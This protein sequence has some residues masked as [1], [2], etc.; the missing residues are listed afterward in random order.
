M[1]IDPAAVQ[2]RWDEIRGREDCDLSLAPEAVRKYLGESE[3]AIV[4]QR[5]LESLIQFA[6]YRI[7]EGPY[8]SE[9]DAAGDL[10][11]C[12]G[13]ETFLVPAV[14]EALSFSEFLRKYTASDRFVQKFHEDLSSLLANW[15]KEKP[16]FSGR[17]YTDLGRV[18]KAVEPVQ[19][20]ALEPFNITETAA[21]ACR[22]TIHVLT[23]KYRNRDEYEFV[24]MIGNRY[25]DDVLLHALSN[26][27]DF[28][29][30]TFQKSSH[31]ENVDQK[32]AMST[33]GDFAGS[34]WSWTASPPG[35]FLPPL[36]FFTAAV[37]D[38][39]AEL[40]LYLIRPGS[41][42]HFTATAPALQK[43][44]WGKQKQLFQLQL[45]VDMARRWV[46]TT[47]IPNL[48][49]G[50]GQHEEVYPGAE[51][52][53]IIYV[54]QPELDAYQADWEKVGLRSPILY[55]NTVYALQILLWSFGD[56]TDD[57]KRI[58]DVSK[59]EINRALTILVY[60]YDSIPVVKQVLAKSRHIFLLPGRG[61]FSVS[62]ERASCEYLDAGFLPLLTRLLVLF[63]VYGVGD[64]NV[65]EPIIRSLYVELL[66]KRNR[67]EIQY[68]ALWSIEG[69]EIYSTQR[70]IQAL[71]FYH[72]YA[73][74]KELVDQRSGVDTSS[75]SSMVEFRNKTGI[76]IHLE[77]VGEA[78]TLGTTIMSNGL[79]SSREAEFA[80]LFKNKFGDDLG[81]YL[82]R[83]NFLT[84]PPNDSALDLQEKTQKL[85]LMVFGAGLA[86]KFRDS[87]VAE[88]LLESLLA[89]WANPMD[90]K[91][92]KESEFEL[93]KFLY[94]RITAESNLES[95]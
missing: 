76:P 19:R 72:A 87:T 14:E 40:D 89:L 82:N 90:K 85:A 5:I 69:I 63:V 3:A 39:F 64:R 15:N 29:V 91:R 12:E 31:G 52:T 75:A 73:A 41:K 7:N 4:R 78:V 22:V 46:R 32:I 65:L 45:C 53:K 57:G 51:K 56:R 95:V 68:G 77:L 67:S 28:L 16:E 54:K 61:I 1:P 71:T 11:T 88:S 86:G 42:N 81:A 49:F 2:R 34:G 21:M 48:A 25:E 20:A 93:L 17:P 38:A 80:A 13:L 24:T 10:A 8:H 66:Q 36:L 84:P 58:D 70:A 94:G 74:G 62:D 30:D 35:I 79:E 83:I 92:P 33:W 27:V 23:L 50:S 55:Y 44:F 37:V 26:A 6:D 59:N 18:R 60:S 9:N 43:F 47:V